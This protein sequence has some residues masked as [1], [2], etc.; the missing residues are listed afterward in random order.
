VY[1]TEA[2]MPTD[3]AYD[4][5]RVTNYAEEENE[6]ARQDG[7]DLLDEARDLALPRTTIYQQN[8]HRYHSRRIHGRSFQEGD[9]VL[10]LIQDKKGMHELPPLGKDCS[11]SVARSATT[12]TTSSTFAKTTKASHSPGKSSAP[13]TSTSSIG[14]TPRKNM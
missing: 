13:G 14:S 11:S 3:I 9:L 4:S 12:P 7:I 8:L 6:H 5:P 10:W 1:G 2:V